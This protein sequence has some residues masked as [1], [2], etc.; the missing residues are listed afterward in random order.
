MHLATVSKF[1]VHPCPALRR[2]SLSEA[3]EEDPTLPTQWVRLARL[4]RLARSGFCFSSAKFWPVF[5]SQGARRLWVTPLMVHK[6]FEATGR[7][8][9]QHFVTHLI[10]SLT[11]HSS[12]ASKLGCRSTLGSC[13]RIGPSPRRLAGGAMGEVS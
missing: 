5:R 13:T 7:C 3:S 6:Y 10:Y 2:A 4:A 12:M 1:T 9:L 11:V 8:S